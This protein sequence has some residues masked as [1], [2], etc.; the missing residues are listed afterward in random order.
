VIWNCVELLLS[1][2]ANGMRQAY[3]VACV[4]EW[5]GEACTVFCWETGRKVT[6]CGTKA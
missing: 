3:H 5:R 4:G 1:N 2:C 6:T